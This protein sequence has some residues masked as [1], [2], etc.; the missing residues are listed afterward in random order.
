M[1]TEDIVSVIV[2][3]YNHEAYIIDSLSSITQQTY[4]NKQLIVID[5]FSMDRTA[6]LI[7]RYL[8]REV[9]HELFPGGIEFIRHQKNMNAYSTINEGIY[10]ANGKYISVINSDDCYERN[11]LKVMIQSLKDNHAKFAFSKVRCFDENGN[12]MENTQF[13]GIESA[14]KKYPSPTFALPIKNVA[15]GSGNFVFERKLFDEIGG[16]GEYHFIHDWDFALKAAILG[17]PLYVE[18][19]TYWY[20]LHSSNTI[21][22]IEETETNRIKKDREVKEVLENY[23]KVI[24]KGKAANVVLQDVQLWDYFMKLESEQ[25]CSYLW[26]GLKVREC[27]GI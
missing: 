14:L 7:D 16:F 12:R 23:L 26:E 3:A 27:D 18:E 10:L 19:T 21:K 24:L 6:D 4:Y 9:V 13:L 20:R 2:P 17:E 25:Y 22:Q 15:V 5:D 1:K 8:D 11:R